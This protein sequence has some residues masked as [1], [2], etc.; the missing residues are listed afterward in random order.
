[1]E[2][3]KANTLFLIYKH[4]RCCTCE[5]HNTICGRHIVMKMIYSYNRLILEGASYG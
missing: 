2:L 5:K 3:L 1:M 4:A